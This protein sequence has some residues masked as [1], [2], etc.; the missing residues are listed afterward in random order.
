MVDYIEPTHASESLLNGLP[1][2]F[3]HNYEAKV[4]FQKEIERYGGG[5]SPVSSMT[6][7][8][9]NDILLLNKNNG[10]VH[11]IVNGVLLKEP[12][13]DVDVANKRERGML[14]I[15]TTASSASNNDVDNATKYIF[16]YY[17]QSTKD[18]NDIC[19][20]AYRCESGTEPLGNRLY[21]YELSDDKLV[22][23]RLLLSLPATP[24]PTHNGGAV[25]IG[26][27]NNVYVTIGDVHGHADNR[28]KTKAQ[29]FQD[30]LDPDGRSAILRVSKN[31]EIP[32]ENI[33]GNLYPLNFYYA[34][35]IRNSFGIDFDPISGK[36]WDTENGP[37]YGDEINLVE[38]GFNSGWIELQGIW[39]PRF[40]EVNGGDFIAGDELLY[41]TNHE[42]VDFDGKGNYS[43]PEF[44]WK[45]PV[46]ATAIKFLHSD[47]YGKEYKDDLFV[48][49]VNNGY[50]YHF[51][52]NKERSGLVLRDKL[53]DKIADTDTDDDLNQ[54]KFGE[55][56]GG[57]TDIEVGP[58]G[59][60]YI[61]SFEKNTAKIFKIIPVI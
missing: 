21:R 19:P 54:I 55:G 60:L 48:G 12:L 34:Y 52:L 15:A 45:K 9:T 51:D 5:L 53:Q 2:I 38:P 37:D 39:K 57:I 29:N 23:P 26:P 24:G 18:G 10:M 44:I 25:E 11:R 17:T 40:D 14:G 61:L 1:N 28:S 46:G 4:I 50:L 6:F 49:D 7:L 47:K 35:G 8:D 30:G 27:D 16:L 32:E 20:L 58:D 33:L 59:Y 3:D 36:L 56:F 22:N 13:L 41:P 42:L 43:A 31:G